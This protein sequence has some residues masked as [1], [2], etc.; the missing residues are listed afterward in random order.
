[1]FDGKLY[2]QIGGVAMGSP[3]VLYWQMFLCVSLKIKI[4]VSC[5]LQFKPVL[6]HH[7]ID[8]NFCLFKESFPPPCL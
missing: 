6:Y 2:D 4:Q 1:M 5:P 7:Y 3:L 8:D